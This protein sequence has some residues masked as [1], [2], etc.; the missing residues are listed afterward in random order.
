MSAAPQDRR[1]VVEPRHGYRRFEPPPE[2]GELESF[3]RHGYADRARAGLAAPDLARL[4]STD[5][6]A[7]R[8]RA[9]LRATLWSDVADLLRRHA[10]GRRVLDVGCGS[11]DLL[12]HLA[13]EGFAADGLEPSR[14]MSAAARERGLAVRC[15]RLEDD[16]E[17]RGAADRDAVLLINVLE[18]VPDPAATLRAAHRR[19]LP[20]GLLVVRVPNDFSPLQEAAR[21]RLEREPWWLCWP[22]HVSYFDFRSLAS[23]L[24]AHGFAPLETSGDFPMELFLLLG[25][26]YLA[27]AAVGKRCHRRRRRFERALP[28]ALRRDL[29]RALA[30]VG[31]GRNCLL[32]ARRDGG[33]ETGGAK[34]TP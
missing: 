5:A 1:L 9:W 7:R 30:G 22:D 27:D 15:G 29:Y 28:S 11:A 20:G 31:I 34:E 2:R 17:G 23:L 25:F 26:D 14:E 8:E 24:A 21:R 32:A 19:L 13:G 12:R 16:D 33:S 10:P 4:L 6:E 18:H 3:Y